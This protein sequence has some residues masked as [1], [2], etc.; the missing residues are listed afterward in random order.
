[1]SDLVTKYAR[2][3]DL[4]LTKTRES[5][6]SWDYDFERKTLSVR[7]GGI[8][9]HLS[10][11]QSDHFEEDYKIS[12][13]NNSGDYIEGFEDSTLSGIELPFGEDNYYVRMKDLFSL[14]MRQATGAD[15][16]LDEFIQ[17]LDSDTLDDI[18]F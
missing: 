10:C 13:Y 12:L 16:A 11:S 18:P 2:L 5:K 14:A 6:V 3:V 4:L 9:L 17:A 7:N 1:M 8:I 15:K